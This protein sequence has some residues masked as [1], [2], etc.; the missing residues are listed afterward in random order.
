MA[1]DAVRTA[2]RL[3]AREVHLIYR[4]QREDMPAHKEE[5]AAA[6]HEGTQ[7]H[8]L[9][10]PLRV[11]GDGRVA[12]L[13]LQRQSLGDFDNSGRRRPMPMDGAELRSTWTW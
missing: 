8:F 1:I 10:N 12:G 7:F 4:R 11:L 2:W 6:E 5:I 9:A 13:V 3:G